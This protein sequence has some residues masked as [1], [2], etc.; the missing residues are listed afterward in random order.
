MKLQ[1]QVHGDRHLAVA[2]SL[3]SLGKQ[4]CLLNADARAVGLLETSLSIRKEHCILEEMDLD[5]AEMLEALGMALSKCGEPQRALVVHEEALLLRK[6]LQGEGHL[7]VARTLAHLGTAHRTLFQ[8]ERAFLLFEQELD[9]ERTVLGENHAQVASTLSTLA[10]MAQGLGKNDRALCFLQEAL[11]IQEATLGKRHALVGRTLGVLAGI[12]KSLGRTD[13]AFDR[14][15]Q[16]LQA[17]VGD[18]PSDPSLGS[19]RFHLAILAKDLSKQNGELAVQA[20]QKAYGQDHR[21]TKDAQ[22]LVKALQW[23]EQP[24]IPAAFLSMKNVPA[25]RRVSFQDDAPEVKACDSGNGCIS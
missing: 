2:K 16:A 1:E 17:H 24:A 6:K 8:D 13:D 11:A 12:L 25:S 3:A 4:H 23:T 19:I 18:D 21:K 9:I 10:L 14:Y 22:I 5:V 15:R 7:D 20:L